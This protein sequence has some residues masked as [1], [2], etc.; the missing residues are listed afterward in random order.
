VG[1]GDRVEDGQPVATLRYEDGDRSVAVISKYK[2]T[3]VELTKAPGERMREQL[4][5]DT[6][7]RIRVDR[8]KC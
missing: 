6:V 1:A 2:G 7:A 3:V 8:L 4:P 5:W